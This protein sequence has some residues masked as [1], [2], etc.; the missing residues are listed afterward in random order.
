M[1][2]GAFEPTLLQFQECCLSKDVLAITARGRQG[3][4][5]Y[6]RY[7]DIHF[8]HIISNTYSGL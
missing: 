3:D 4:I 8:R 1:F 7:Y 5:V 2:H 6:I